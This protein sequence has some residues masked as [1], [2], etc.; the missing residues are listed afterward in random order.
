[1]LHARPGY[2]WRCTSSRSQDG[3]RRRS[4]RSCAPVAKSGITDAYVYDSTTGDDAEWKAANKQLQGL[5]LFANTNLPGKA[6]A[7]GFA[8]LYTYDVRIYDG[9][10]FPRMC[11][12]ARM[13][14]LLCAPSVGPGFDSERATGDTRIQGRANGKTY[15]R[16]WRGAIRAA[17]DVV[18]ITS[19]NE[20][21]EGTQIEPASAIGATVRVIRRCVRPHRPR[22][23]ACVSR[24][25]RGV[26]ARIPREDR[27]AEPLVEGRGQPAAIRADDRIFGIESFEQ[28]HR[29]LAQPVALLRPGSRHGVDDEP[30]CPFGVTRVERRDDVG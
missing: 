28:R 12:S 30:K 29:D 22:C 7:G 6:E 5:R 2:G 13:H 19:Y 1:M 20:W 27:A 24:P 21:H 9:K 17:A 4:S 15:D 3:R 16:M 25:H 26:G 23:A 14:N 11:A 10:S 8:G 18:T